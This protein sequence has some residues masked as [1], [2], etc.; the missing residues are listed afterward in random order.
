MADTL[1][2]PGQRLAL[3]C[4]P[5][6]FGK[7]TLVS[8]WTAAAVGSPER[9]VSVAWLSLDEAD[10]ELGRLV[11][12]MLAAL[13]R[14]GMPLDS[15]GLAGW[16]AG[17]VDVATAIGLLTGVVNSVAH[18]VDVEAVEGTHRW[19]LVLDDYH[20]I[21]APEVHEILTYLLDHAPEQLRVLV[22]TR[23]DPP[24]PLAR[25]R[26]RGQLTELRATD[27]RFTA[28]EAS[29]FLNE[30]MGLDLTMAD[31]EA[32]DDRTE[33]WAAGLQLAGLSL[34][35]RGQRGDVSAFIEAFTGSNRFVVDY[36]ADEVLDD[37]WLYLSDGGHLDNTGL[38]EA[39][40]LH[41]KGG[42]SWS[43]TP[44]TTRSTRGRRWGD[45]IGV[46]RAVPTSAS[47]CA[48]CTARCP[49]PNPRTGRSRSL[50]CGIAS[51]AGSG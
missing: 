18:A 2:E 5:A 38:V 1:L 32:L 28:H 30:V 19:L 13:E 50:D 26:S 23:S 44:A 11:A 31:V 36:L 33:G 37:R 8:S 9:S 27:L 6:G 41:R 25:L 16:S 47:T 35:G 39:A 15:G 40:R 46:I 14:A 24:L 3:V 45:A 12:H 29:D 43:W 42:Q 48:A 21:T 4:A 34:R 17:G 7:T 49:R 10:N 22:A 51:C 20:V